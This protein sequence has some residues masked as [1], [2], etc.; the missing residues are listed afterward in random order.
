MLTSFTL[1]SLILWIEIH[2]ILWT[3]IKAPHKSTITK[4][5]TSRCKF[6]Q[7]LLSNFVSWIAFLENVY[8]QKKTA[9]SL[10]VCRFAIYRMYVS[11]WVVCVFTSRIIRPITF[12]CNIYC[13]FSSIWTEPIFQKKKYWKYLLLASIDKL[14]GNRR[15]ERLFYTIF[16]FVFV[17]SFVALRSKLSKLFYNY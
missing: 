17:V 4:T 2:A 10:C 6:R 5:T 14:R 15:R 13:L 16:S 7:N 3:T 11:I 9:R 12:I 1:V 8:F